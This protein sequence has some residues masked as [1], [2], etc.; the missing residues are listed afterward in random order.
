[1][2]L[3]QATA[4]A[5][6]STS[7]PG[8]KRGPVGIGIIG[9]GMISDAYLVNLVRFPDVRVVALGDLNEAL[10]AEKAQTYGVPFSG[11]PASVLANEEVEIV[12]N[13]TIP[14][15]HVPVALDAIAAGKHVWI[16]KPIGIN[17][18]E[19]KALL[20][21]ADAAGL[22][23]GVAPDTVLNPG[24]QT[25]LR[26][27]A[28]GAIGTPL[29]A[30]TMMRY[31]GPDLFHPNPAFLF[32][33]GGGPLLDMGPYYVT[34]LVSAF[35]P[36]R[37]VYATG[38]TAKETRT[39]KLGPLTG[40][41]FPVSVLTH[42]DALVTFESGASAQL[43]FSND[44]PLAEMGTVEIIGAGG[45]LLT[46]DPNHAD[47]GTR[48]AR[49]PQEYAEVL[50]PT[51]EDYPEEGTVTGRGYGALDMA[52]GIREGLP[53]VATGDL[54]LHVLDIMLAIEESAAAG[55]V[56]VIESTVDPVPLVDHTRDPF[57][58]TLSV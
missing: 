9:T 20:V 35:G 4:A 11:S 3:P 39:V 17:R 2:S 47:G 13:L 41:S 43:T 40:Q 22:R 46:P 26:H 56:V 38:S 49:H 44:S 21:A 48:V 18:E 55:E 51:W 19:A 12:I 57:A 14:A 34:T 24:I 31:S 15:V 32:A 6:A 42:V 45:M 50:E 33:Q 58:A 30:R 28:A 1:M 8:A 29:T 54:A 53:H 52:R 23:V 5:A 10:A 7:A 36:V 37:K 25:A 16:E 27:L